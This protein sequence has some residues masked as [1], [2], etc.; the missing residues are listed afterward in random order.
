MALTALVT[1]RAHLAN[2]AKASAEEHFVPYYSTWMRHGSGTQLARSEGCYESLH[3]Q[4]QRR[5][6]T[7]HVPNRTISRRALAHGF[8]V[9]T[10]C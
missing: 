4:T 6:K 2:A 1:Q 9:A 5:R 7:I 10:V 3:E 8:R